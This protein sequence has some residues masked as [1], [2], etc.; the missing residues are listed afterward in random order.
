MKH[1]KILILTG[2]LGYALCLVADFILEFVNGTHLTMEAFADFEAF[3]RLTEGV[4]AGR[5]AVSGILGLS[6]MVLIALGMVGLY[7]F[8]KTSAPV[9]SEFV[10]VGGVG[11]AVLGGGFHLLCT[12][13]PWFFVSLGRTEEAFNI[14]QQFVSA[15]GIVFILNPIFY[16]LMS[17]PLFIILV[18]KKTVLPRW[19]CVFNLVLLFFILN[20]IHVP[21]AT[22]IAG[23]LMCGGI[24]VLSII[25]EKRS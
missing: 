18:T 4:T 24:F 19:S 13:E 15:H 16:T 1:S 22:S 2:V 23:L 17:V 8:T 3:Y 12:L 5:F 6:S 9:L 7:E 21:G 20:A 11:S 10:L 25:K 14:L